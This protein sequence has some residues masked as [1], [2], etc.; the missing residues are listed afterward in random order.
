MGGLDAE[1]LGEHGAEQGIVRR[2]EFDHRACSQP[3]SEIGEIEHEDLF[4]RVADRGR[5]VD[6]ERS[7]LDALEQVGGGDVAQIEGRILAHQHDIGI[8]AEV[9]DL[10][11]AQAIMVALR[12]LHGHGPGHRPEPPLGPAQRVR[13]IVP[14]PVPARLVQYRGGHRIDFTL[15]RIDVLRRI[16]DQDALP[17]WLAAGKID[18]LINGG[19][20]VNARDNHG[21]TPLHYAGWIGQLFKFNEQ[22]S[23][24]EKL[25][26][27]GADPFLKDHD[28]KTAL[29]GLRL[30]KTEGLV[31]TPQDDRAATYEMDDYG[32]L[33][34]PAP[35]FAALFAVAGSI[36]RLVVTIGLLVS[37]HPGL[38]ILAIA[39]LP[40]VL[41][42]SR[43]AQPSAQFAFGGQCQVGLQLIQHQFTH[44]LAFQGSAHLER[45]M[46]CARD[47][48]D[49]QGGHVFLLFSCKLHE[50]SFGSGAIV[51]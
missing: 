25:L 11:L 5:V 29:E 47:I 35:R 24:V 10:G 50:A 18:R 38:A 43:Q 3:G 48:A 41:V 21:R 13:R 15:S 20:D 51:K 4:G 31:V 46:Q 2:L 26:E 42:S 39:A 8:A 17:D 33:A 22:T 27:R 36:L 23:I 6:D 14:E 32:G 40:T 12:T 30:A 7:G 44:A 19:A 28:G 45:A 16:V 37:V 34:G 49:L 1:T 9:E